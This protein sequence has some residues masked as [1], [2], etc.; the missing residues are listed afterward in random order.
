MKWFYTVQHVISRGKFA[1][2]IIVVI[3]FGFRP[4][5]IL[6]TILS[7]ILSSVSSSI[8]SFS[9][10]DYVFSVWNCFDHGLFLIVFTMVVDGLPFDLI[11]VRFNHFDGVD[12]DGV[13]STMASTMAI[14]I[15]IQRICPWRWMHWISIR[16]VR[17][18]DFDGFDGFD[19]MQF[20]FDA[21]PIL[22]FR[23]ESNHSCL[24][25]IPTVPF[26]LFWFRLDAILILDAIPIPTTP[27]FFL[28]PHTNISISS[29]I[30]YVL[31]KKDPSSIP[32]SLLIKKEPIPS[33]STPLF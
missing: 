8:S 27:A 22:Q 16:G 12:F 2:F 1:I 29:Y 31:I 30:L 26:R 25:S 32:S 5:S 10:F 17:W 7:S 24:F 23:F 13:D 3:Y 6:S 9:K 11:V 18:M 15:S 4:Y 14:R 28:V 21:I 20:R 19:S 33:S